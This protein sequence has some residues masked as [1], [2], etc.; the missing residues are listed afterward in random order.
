MANRVD[1]DQKLRSAASNLGYTVCKGL[2]VPI[3]RVITILT[4]DSHETLDL[5]FSEKKEIRM[6]SATS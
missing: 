2:S 6:S 4:D 1:P 5:I 3:L